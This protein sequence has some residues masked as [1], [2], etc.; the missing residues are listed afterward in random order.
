MQLVVRQ[1]SGIGN[2]MFQYAAGVY[3]ARLHG[4]RMSMAIDPP[5]HANSHGHPRPFLLPQ[6]A[7]QAPCHE[8]NPFE[9]FLILAE[10]RGIKQ[11]SGVLLR[12]GLR[13]EVA[14]ETVAQRFHFQP[15]L[16]VRRG[17]RTVYLFGYWQVH[18]IAARVERELRQEFTFRE[19]PSGNN[20][21]ILRRIE[22]ADQ[23]VSLHIRRGDYTLA[24]EGNVALQMD[25]YV[26]AI[27]EI[28]ATV[29]DPLFFVFSD[30]I[31]FARNNLPAG[32]SAVFVDHNDAF[33]AH[34]DLRL[35]SACKH[36]IIA[37]STFS[38]WGAWLNARGDKIVIAP[39]QWMVGN[40]ARYDDLFPPPWRLLG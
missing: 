18:Q 13:V 31:G 33:S 19:P 3:Y 38:W 9:R 24:V 8:L 17:T 22:S 28:R 40:H 15:Q 21:A 11:I 29:R 34:E 20:A 37:N 1:L 5:L 7:I 39:R 6:F 12:H 35:M 4:A 26:R 10:H 14:T 32:I 30:D 23:P 2:Q 36:H 27:A 25:Y 16:P